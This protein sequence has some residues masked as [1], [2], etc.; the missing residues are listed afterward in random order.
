VEELNGIRCSIVEKGAGAARAE[1]LK[2]LL[3]INNLEVVTVEEKRE[4]EESPVT[5]TIGVTDIVFNP[6][7]AV[8]QLRLKTGDGRIVSPPY[9]NQWTEKIDNKYWRF[10]RSATGKAEEIPDTF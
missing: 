7:V 6:V 5:Y 4:T 1:F 3:E 2:K 9:W 8:Y 10:R